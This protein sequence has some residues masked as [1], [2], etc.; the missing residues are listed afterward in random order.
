MSNSLDYA[1]LDQGDEAVLN[2]KIQEQLGR[3]PGKRQRRVP[4][5]PL[6]PLPQL[7]MGELGKAQRIVAELLAIAQKCKGDKRCLLSELSAMR[8]RRA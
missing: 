4:Q 1:S 6:P 8:K 5:P 2:R 3:E 7:P